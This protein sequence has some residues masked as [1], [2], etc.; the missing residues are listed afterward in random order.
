MAGKPRP[1]PAREPLS[2]GQAPAPVKPNSLIEYQYFGPSARGGRLA[3]WLWVLIPAALL[4][5]VTVYPDASFAWYLRIQAIS[6]DI[7][8]DLGFFKVAQTPPPP[9]PPPPLAQTKPAPP[10]QPPIAALPRTLPI[11]KPLERPAPKPP[12]PILNSNSVPAGKIVVGYSITPDNFGHYHSKGRINGR[13]VDFLL[14]TGADWVSIPDRIRWQFNLIRGEFRR[15]T[16]ADDSYSGYA[17]KIADLQVGPLHLQ[18][19]DGFLDPKAQGNEIVLGMSALQSLGVTQ[20]NKTLMLKQTQD[21][22]G[23]Q[24]APETERK[25]P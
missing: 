14:D 11:K 1:D 3:A 24:A 8:H 13:D 18:N 20:K 19:V 5:A 12:I 15:V 2:Q 22:A 6:L 4:A 23:N 17:V 7:L 16:T 21:A 25:I 9:L 10:T